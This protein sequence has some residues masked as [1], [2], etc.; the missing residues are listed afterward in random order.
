MNQSSPL[1]CFRTI[2]IDIEDFAES[3]NSCICTRQF[4]ANFKVGNFSF[5]A[6]NRAPL[7]K[8]QSMCVYVLAETWNSYSVSVQMIDE[9]RDC[10]SSSVS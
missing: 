8:N 5:Q 2:Y 3:E 1:N 7:Q 4:V 10:F 9:T 6:T